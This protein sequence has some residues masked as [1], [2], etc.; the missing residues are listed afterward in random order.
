MTPA[1]A[2]LESRIKQEWDLCQKASEDGR[3]QD[4]NLHWETFVWLIK[5]RRKERVGEMER[6]RGLG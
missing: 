5:Q 6:E 4:A 1:D 3:K 2:A